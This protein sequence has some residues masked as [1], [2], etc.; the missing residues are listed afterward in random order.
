MNFSERINQALIVAAKAHDGQTRKGTDIPYISHPVA[1]ALLASEHTDDEDVIIGALFHDILEDVSPEVYSE[2]RMKTD[3]GDR[4]ANL[5]KAVSEDKRPDEPEKPWKERKTTYINHLRQ[6]TDTGAIVISAAD[7]T[8]NLL[9]IIQDYQ[10][11]GDDLWSRFNAPKEGQLWYY[12]AVTGVVEEK[13][14]PGVL[15]DRLVELTRQ[16]GEIIIPTSVT[17]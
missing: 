6:E 2:A 7:K 10:T 4:V 8:H 5:V 16:L 3:F 9:S 12:Q 13:L 15:T 14:E 17:N 1:V 11:H